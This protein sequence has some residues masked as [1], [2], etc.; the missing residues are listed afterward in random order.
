VR[1]DVG[2]TVRRWA[3]ASSLRFSCP[4][5]VTQHSA[6]LQQPLL[7][8]GKLLPGE[9][10]QHGQ[11]DS[12]VF[13]ELCAWNRKFRQ[14]QFDRPS[15]SVDFSYSARVDRQVAVPRSSTSPRNSSQEISVVAEQSHDVKV[16]EAQAGTCAS[17]TFFGPVPPAQDRFQRD[18]NR[19]REQELVIR[20]Q[21][22]RTV[23]VSLSQGMKIESVRTQSMPPGSHL[24]NDLNPGLSPRSTSCARRYSA[25]PPIDARIAC[26]GRCRC[27][28]GFF[29]R[30]LLFPS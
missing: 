19:D 20:P 5:R 26:S 28:S 18:A 11:L 8:R 21:C 15:I 25:A 4:R 6:H 14:Y 27:R 30:N 3:Q 22:L 9:H 29:I 7:P 23:S 10:Q 12:A 24:V 1:A 16:R 13:S 2:G 17:L